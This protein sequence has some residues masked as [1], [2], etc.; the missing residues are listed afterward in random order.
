MYIYIYDAVTI[1]YKS[2]LKIMNFYYNVKR[3]GERERD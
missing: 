2:F 3:G 1:K